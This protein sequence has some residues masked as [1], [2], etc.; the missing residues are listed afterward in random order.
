M[1]HRPWR[2]VLEGDRPGGL[3]LPQNKR[4]YGSEVLGFYK[5]LAAWLKPCPYEEHSRMKSTTA[6]YGSEEGSILASGSQGWQSSA[7]WPRGVKAG[8]ARLPV[9]AWM[10][11]FQDKRRA[12]PSS[13]R[14]PAACET[15]SICPKRHQYVV[16]CPRDDTAE[17]GLLCSL[18]DGP[19]RFAKARQPGG[20]RGSN[21]LKQPEQTHGINSMPWLQ[22]PNRLR[23]DVG[24]KHPTAFRA[25]RRPKGLPTKS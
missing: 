8:Q 25:R 22:L 2:A 21:P 24:R 5:R 15:T 6:A 10:L 12:D 4:A 13:L 19:S 20:S 11:L 18:P 9:A 14:S 7:E 3:S 23:R 16:S 17:R 1:E